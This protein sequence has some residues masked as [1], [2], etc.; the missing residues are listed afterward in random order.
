MMFFQL[1]LLALL[2]VASCTSLDYPLN[3]TLTS[4][5]NTV[6]QLDIQNVGESDLTL[7][8]RGS[9]FDKRPVKK[10]TV[11]SGEGTALAFRGMNVD[12]KPIT[13]T[14]DVTALHAGQA[15][16]VTFDAMAMYDLTSAGNFTAEAVGTVWEAKSA[17]FIPYKSN[18]I[19]ITVSQP[20]ATVVKRQQQSQQPYSLNP[21]PPASTD[22]IDGWA[23]AAMIPTLPTA[24]P[25]SKIQNDCKD[26][27]KKK[28]KKAL[29]TCGLY[30]DIAV[31]RTLTMPT[32]HTEFKTYFDSD[33]EADKTQV[34]AR[35]NATSK[36]CTALWYP[37]VLISCSDP[38]EQCQNDNNMRSY[39]DDM[40][41]SA[42]KT[43]FLC[44][45]AFNLSI[46][47]DTDNALD[48][49]GFLL[50]EHT[51]FDVVYKPV[52]DEDVQDF[53][54]AK[55]LGTVRALRNSGSYRI[56]AA[57]YLDVISAL[58]DGNGPDDLNSP[59]KVRS[60]D[61]L[62]NPEKVRSPDDLNN[63][64][65]PE[66]P[67]C[68]ED[69]QEDMTCFD[70]PDSWDGY[71]YVECPNET[72]ID[73]CLRYPTSTSTSTSTS[74][75]TSTST[76]KS[77]S[78]STSKHTSTTT[79]TST[80]KPTSKPTSTTTTKRPGP[81]DPHHH[82]DGPQHHS[83]ANALSGIHLMAPPTNR[84][85]ASEYGAYTTVYPTGAGCF[86]QYENSPCENHGD[87]D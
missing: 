23:L 38:Q 54:A 1:C 18:S 71:D 64:D 65:D 41:S 6:M 83:S 34:T 29:L 13:A 67:Q 46:A 70:P 56:N 28:I 59:E 77:T 5:G 50:S 68:D 75:S 21:L 47:S 10:V 86:K 81:L 36:E 76:S 66:G 49:G 69:S 20:K 58:N 44:P 85:K 84:G 3:V 15:L 57:A 14:T 72:D 25:R 24:L 37:S 17:E 19:A 87:E 7:V 55:L 2:T 4:T 30:A 48:F 11:Y 45:P 78:T 8:T 74:K 60:P 79:S 52:T 33:K 26:D 73:E 22:W 32:D 43:I 12:P 53:K 61:D 82:T 80:S 16:T 9:F 62:N 40:R 35:L 42:D 51:K 39:I 63:P 31:N 27:Q